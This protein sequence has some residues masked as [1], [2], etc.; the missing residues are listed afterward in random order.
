MARSAETC[1]IIEKPNPD[2]TTN[3]HY[4]IILYALFSKYGR[5]TEFKC[6]H[7]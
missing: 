2:L 6:N 4:D 7:G 1:I 3:I 5:E